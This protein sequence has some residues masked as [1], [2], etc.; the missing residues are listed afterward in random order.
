[1][2]DREFGSPSVPIP[3]GVIGAG[4]MGVGVAQVAAAA[5]HAVTL[6]D[7]T[8]AVLD[9]ARRRLRMSL[10]MTALA[11]RGQERPDAAAITERIRFTTELRD[12]SGAGLVVE[13]VTE[14]MAAKEPVY[15]ALDS[16]LPAGAV[17]AA[18]TSC[19]PVARLASWTSRAP[20]VIG[21]HFMNPVPLRDTVEVIRGAATS[22]R[23]LD[24]TLAFLR[25]M[26]MDGIVV[27]DG[28][29][30]VSNRVLMLTLNEAARVADEN[31]ASPAEID[32]VFTKC[33]GH[34]M[35]PLATAD[36]IGLDTVVL[37][38]EVLHA[39][40]GDERFKP[41]GALVSRVEK[42]E[43]GRKSG[44]GFHAY[45]AGRSYGAGRG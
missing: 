39:E 2:S 40:F 8:S 38:L 27:G 25:G 6:V 20:E 12:V 29:G 41:A 44:K 15:R 16:I 22:D 19:I 21:T 26:G 24:V 43:L 4:V 23:T 13:N 10:T 1:M 32:L 7:T 37:S 45:G 3:I 31:T 42:G 30:F 35:G 17:L 34:A 14:T 33:M 11:R 18:N 36:L 9:S 28:P 5:G